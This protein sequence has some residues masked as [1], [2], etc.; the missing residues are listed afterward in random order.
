MIGAA[1]YLWTEPGM[2]TQGILLAFSGGIYTYVA[3]TDAA[4]HMLDGVGRL[5]AQKRFLLLVCY[6]IGA[7]GVGLVLLDHEH[8]SAKDSSGGDDDPHA[9]HNH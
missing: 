1:I 2:G 8:C 4:K 3:C 6:A 5:S 9:G 7:I